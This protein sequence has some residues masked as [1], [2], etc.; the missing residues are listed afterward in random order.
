MVFGLIREAIA[1]AQSKLMLAVDNPKVDLGF[2]VDLISASKNIVVGYKVGTPYILGRSLKSLK[3]LFDTFSGTYFLAD[4]KLGDLAQMMEYVA[5]LVRDAG[6][7]GLVVNA[8]IGYEGALDRI[9]KKCNSLSL[10]LFLQITFDHPASYIIDSRYS[11]IKMVVQQTD[12]TGLIVPASKTTIIRDLRE[13]FGSKYVILSPGIFAAGAEPGEALCYG[14][15]A[16]IVG[17]RVVSAPSPR[18]ALESVLRAQRR[19][20]SEKKDVCLVRWSE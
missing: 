6:F 9:S 5:E 1:R 19:F 10:D 4:L 16:E 15:D 20:L 2:L 13:T 12:P 14:A 8:F 7:S 17:A 3:S 18:E 11:D